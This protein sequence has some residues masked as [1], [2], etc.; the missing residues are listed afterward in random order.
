MSHLILEIILWVL[1]AFFIGCVLGY[2]ARALFGKRAEPVQAAIETSDVADASAGEAVSV[3]RVDEEKASS[4]ISSSRADRPTGIAEPR[5]GKVDNL[6]RISGI[7]PKNERTL[8][9]LGFFHFDQ[10]AGWTDEEVNWVDN[11]LK[12]NGRIVREEW[13]MQASL[14]ADGNDDEF[15]R[16]Y[17]RRARP[18]SDKQ[19][20]VAK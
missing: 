8:H 13:I 20:T 18:L 11:H 19:G 17:G 16:I 15:E 2:L 9:S 1:L 10:I 3:V 14:L 6:Q 5:G 4:G 7:G 12:F